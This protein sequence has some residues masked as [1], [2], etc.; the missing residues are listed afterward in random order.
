MLLLC[1]T[2][3]A[4][5]EEPGAHLLHS[6]CDISPRTAHHLPFALHLA[7]G[8]VFAVCLQISVS[9]TGSMTSQL[10]V[11]TYYGLIKLLAT[12]VSGS[13]TVA[14][15]LLQSGISGTLHKLLRR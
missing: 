12:C 13:H 3:E 14:E 8:H 7:Q 15:D 11:S 9:D 5:L 1:P 2:L 6:V 4:S 10:S